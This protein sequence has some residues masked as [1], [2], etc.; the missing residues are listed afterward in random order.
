[1]AYKLKTNRGILFTIT[2]EDFDPAAYMEQLNNNRI[3]MVSLGGIMM[4]KSNILWVADEKA[5]EEKGKHVIE[6]TSGD[7]INVDIKDFNADAL[8]I[9]FNNHENTFA[10]VGG[11]IV[12]RRGVDMILP[13]DVAGGD[14]V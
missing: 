14:P 13:A 4:Q 11:A 12:N 3:L 7:K 10:L 2:K 1:M 8:T 9:D 6:M 5:L